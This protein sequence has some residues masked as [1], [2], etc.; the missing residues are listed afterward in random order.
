MLLSPHISYTMCSCMLSQLL[1]AVQVKR[2]F[3]KLLRACP[4]SRICIF[5]RSTC[6]KLIRTKA[7]TII[8]NNDACQLTQ[9]ATKQRTYTYHIKNLDTRIILLL[10]LQQPKYLLILP[11]STFYKWP[12]YLPLQQWYG[13]SMLKLLNIS[14]IP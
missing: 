6:Q 5:Y 2:D 8:A 12:K 7:S 4:V 1:Q 13:N 10:K 11:N 14:R 3:K 9:S